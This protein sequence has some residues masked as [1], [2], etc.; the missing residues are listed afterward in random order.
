MSSGNEG[1]ISRW[2]AGLR[3]G[4]DESARVLWHRFFARMVRLARFKLGSAPRAAADEED[5]AISAFHSLCAG[6]VRGN[7]PQL[8]DRDELWRLLTTI[9]VRK[10]LDVVERQG[11]QKRGG[12]GPGAILGSGAARATNSRGLDGVVD[13]ELGPEVTAILAEEYQRLFDDLRDESL[14]RVAR[15]RLEG[16]TGAEIAERLGC[17]RRTVVRKLELIRQTW[18]GVEPP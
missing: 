2:F 15:L 11:R 9:T 1:S 6:V 14:R 16:H 17:N 18:L 5:V 3:S 13:R 10:A 8:D 12:L 4:D 7:F